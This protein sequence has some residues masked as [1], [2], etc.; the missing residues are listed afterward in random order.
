MRELHEF[1]MP[2]V[3]FASDVLLL[4]LVAICTLGVV[5][6]R[7]AMAHWSRDDVIDVFV[8]TLVGSAA[9]NEWLR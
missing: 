9:L 1:L 4:A 6:R 8:L 7:P 3:G 5:I 2:V